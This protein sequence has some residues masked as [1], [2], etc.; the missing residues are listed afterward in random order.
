LIFILANC[1]N[2]RLAIAL[3]R[4]TARYIGNECCVMFVPLVMTGT[5]ILFMIYWIIVAV[6]LYSSGTITKSPTS[7]YAYPEWN[8]YVRYA[9]WFHLFGA[10]WVL[11]FL[12]AY[13]LFVLVSSTCIWYFEVSSKEGVRKPINRS[14]FRGIRFHLG[15]LAF[16]SFIVALIRF[17]I[18]MCEYVKLQIESAGGAS[19]TA[20]EFYKCLITCMECCLACCLKCVEFINKHAYIQIALEGEN[21]CTSALNGFAIIVRNL[22]RWTTLTI[23]GGFFNFLGLLFVGTGTGMIGYVIITNITLWSAKLTSPILPTIIFCIIGI[24]IGSFFMQVFSTSSDAMLHCFILDE[25]LSENGQATHDPPEELSC[26]VSDER[27]F[28]PKSER[29]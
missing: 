10:L 26:F 7:F 13:N 16:G 21:F 15:S 19:G 24:L 8:D 28:D 5:F 12:E 17:A 14:F 3:I 29:K 27:K 11:S 4:A 2:I 6:Y 9:F 25:E 1:N 22:G 18:V 20:S 23:I